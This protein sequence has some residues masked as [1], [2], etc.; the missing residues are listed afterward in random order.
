MHPRQGRLPRVMLCLAGVLALAAGFYA[1][2]WGVA[3]DAWFLGFQRG[4]ESHV[5]GRLVKSRQDGLFSAGGLLGVGT[6]RFAK[7]AQPSTQGMHFR[8]ADLATGIH[9]RVPGEDWPAGEEIEEQYRAYRD[10]LRFEIFSPYLSQSGGQGL[11]FGVLDG[12]LP[13]ERDRRLELFYLTCAMLSA[14]A[15]GAI[16]CWFA[17]ELSLGVA[18]WVLVTALLSQWL[19]GFGRNLWWGLW[20]FYVPMLVLLQYERGVRPPAVKR[21]GTL[22]ALAYGALLLKCFVN[23]YEYIT[24]S[25]VML[26]LPTAYYALEHRARPAAFLKDALALALGAGAA[27][28]TSLAVLIAQVATL[29]GTAAYG[30]K[31]VV[32]S[33]LARTHGA[34]DDFPPAYGPA[35]AASHASVLSSYLNGAYFDLRGRSARLD[36][37]L[38]DFLLAPRYGA[39]LSLFALATLLLFWL[40]RHE[41]AAEP[42]RDRALIGATWLSLLAPLSWFVLFKAHSYEHAHMN[43]ILWQMPF[44]LF[45]FALTGEALA[46]LFKR[47]R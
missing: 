47:L 11:V 34:P 18:A 6:S 26:L 15:V 31:H 43:F 40:G 22:A 27:I 46:R 14:S 2:A 39:L 29:R 33:L 12:S 42:R 16:A 4:T 17:S 19:V 5:L 37:A 25:L 23:G 36:A 28:L 38:P 8:R 32:F 7:P 3:R 45:G 1:N 24:A 10:G 20:A 41:P 9:L 35:L 30:W 44:T 13:L 21:R